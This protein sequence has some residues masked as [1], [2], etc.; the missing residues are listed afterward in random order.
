MQQVH[1]LVYILLQ[2]PSGLAASNSKQ[3]VG[4]C[5]DNGVHAVTA[6]N[7]LPPVTSYSQLVSHSFS[8]LTG[9]PPLP[10]QKMPAPRAGSTCSTC[11]KQVIGICDPW[12]SCG[13]MQPFQPAHA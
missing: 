11:N 2:V 3:G 7:V 12:A 4:I 9:D 1:A 5:E 8:R 10:S 6:G 13:P